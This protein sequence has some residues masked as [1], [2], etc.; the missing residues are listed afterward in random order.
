MTEFDYG[1]AAQIWALAFSSVV[2]LYLV[3]HG[4]GVLLRFI[5]ES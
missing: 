3:A 2:G 4:I 1:Y 5:R